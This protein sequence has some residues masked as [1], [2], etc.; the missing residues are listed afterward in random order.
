[1]FWRVR[2]C[3]LLFFETF[4]IDFFVVFPIISNANFTEFCLIIHFVAD[5]FFFFL[6][7]M[8]ILRDLNAKKISRMS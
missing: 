5:R 6:Q 2:V 1:M 8:T 3:I 7:I 4:L